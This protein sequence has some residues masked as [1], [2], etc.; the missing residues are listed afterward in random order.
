M[1]EVILFKKTQKETF[2]QALFCS[3]LIF[4]TNDPIGAPRVI[5]QMV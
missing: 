1:R 2:R 3:V 4:F 5:I